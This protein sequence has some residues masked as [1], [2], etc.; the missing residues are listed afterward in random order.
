MLPAPYRYR[1]HAVVAPPHTGSSLL[2][3]LRDI[4]SSKNIGTTKQIAHY[5][6]PINIIYIHSL[7]GKFLLFFNFCSL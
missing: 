3:C 5:F 6:R 1:K 2:L 7:H 4:V